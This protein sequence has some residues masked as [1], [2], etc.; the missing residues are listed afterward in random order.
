MK[1]EAGRHCTPRTTQL[2]TRSPRP[3]VGSSM[4]HKAK[5]LSGKAQGSSG[6]ARG[7][8]AKVADT[9]PPFIRLFSFYSELNEKLFGL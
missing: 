3:A 2:T 6:W 7:S 1:V 5:G 9:K 8:A 4:C